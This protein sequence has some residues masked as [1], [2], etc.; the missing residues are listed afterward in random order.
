MDNFDRNGTTQVCRRCNRVITIDTETNTYVS[1]W[2]NDCDLPS[3]AIPVKTR[4][5]RVYCCKCDTFTTMEEHKMDV[6][7]LYEALRKYGGGC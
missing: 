1:T 5:I 2:I 6:D 3:Y 4:K 7:A